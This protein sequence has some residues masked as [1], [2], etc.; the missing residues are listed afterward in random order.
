MQL[1]DTHCH[2]HSR[3]FFTAAQAETAYQAA[4]RAQVAMLCIGTNLADSRAAITFAQTHDGCW[5]SIGIH[6]HEATTNRRTLQQLATLARQP[7][8]VGVGECGLDFYY[9]DRAQTLKA[10]QQTLRYQI[11]LALEHN[12]PLSFHV[13][14]AFADFWPILADYPATRGVLHSFTDQPPHLQ[15]ALARGLLI[16]VN[17]IATF[18]TQ[19]WQR[20]LFADLP[21][22]SLLLETDAP[23]LTP[24]PKRGRINT[25]ENVI[26]ITKFLAELRNQAPEV[27]AA[28]TTQN[29]RQLWSLV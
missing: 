24:V 23:F 9:N 10:Q 12:L 1:I 21:L 25:P 13:R 14:S 17:G 29:A 2:L 3:E 19:A 7:K 6:P 16:G 4:R 8:V 22:E 20:Q 26:Y 27:I 15:E 18:T 11:E 28:A 5:A